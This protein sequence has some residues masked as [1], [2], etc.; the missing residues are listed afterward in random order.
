LQSPLYLI[1]TDFEKAFD[2]INRNK[3][4]KAM[5]IV[6]LPGKII[7][8]IQ[9]IYKNYTCQVEHNG[10][11][12]ESIIV[13][14]GVKQ[15]RLLLPIL[16]LMVLDIMMTKA[17]NRKKCIQW[18]LHYKLQ[19]LDFADDICILALSFKDMEAKLNDL[20][21]EAQNTGMKTNPQKTK[22][23]RV[24]PKNKDRGYEIEEVNKFCYLGHKVSQHGGANEDVTNRINKVRGAFAQLRPA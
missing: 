4:W 17:M 9:E 14:S 1:F 12:S 5:R 10:K 24:N 3:M 22:E 6:G 20:K 19:D 11:L 18:G 15:E 2:F 23:M 13:E 16:F 21:V 8:L 7:K